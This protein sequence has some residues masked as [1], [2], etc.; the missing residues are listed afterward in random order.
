MGKIYRYKILAFLVIIAFVTATILG[1]VP[2]EASAIYQT[3]TDEI[4]FDENNN[5]YKTGQVIV[6]YR[7]SPTAAEKR[8]IRAT[9]QLELIS[10]MKSINSEVIK[11]TNEKAQ[12]ALSRLS[13]NPNVLFAEYNYLANYDYV[14]NDVRYPYQIYLHYMNASGAWDYTKGSAN[15]TIAVID[16]GILKGNTDL[17][18]ISA[19]GYNV[20]DSSTDYSDP[21]GHGTG[22]I[23][24][25]GAEMDNSFGFA[26]VAPES[27]FMVLRVIDEQGY[28][29]YSDMILALEYAMNQGVD[30]INMSVSGRSDS[31]SLKMAI[32]DAYNSGISIIASAGNE[33]STMV[34]YPAAYDNVIGV[35]AVNTS[36]ELM[37]FSNTGNGLT[38]V[39]GGSAMI[40]T[41][42]DYITNASGTSFASPYVA[43]LVG[44]MYAVDDNMTPAKAFNILEATST[45]LGSSGYDTNFGYGLINMGAAVEMAA[46]G[47]SAPTPEPVTDTTPPV[48]TLNGDNQVSIELGS[49]Y[50]DPG[51][52]AIDDIDGDIS[53]DVVVSGTIDLS[54]VGSYTLNYVVTDQAGNESNIESRIV[55]VYDGSQVTQDITPPVL[56]LNGSD[57][58]DVEIGTSYTELGASAIDDYDG[59]LSDNVVIT[60][61]VDVSTL[62][63]YTLEYS[64]T[65]QAGNQS[66]VE[67]RVVEVF[68]YVEEPIETEI[69]RDVEIVSG[70]LNK[71][72]T[73]DTHT[74][75][76]T[77]AGQLD[78]DFAYTGKV[79]P[80]LTVDGQTI[81]GM[82]GTLNVLEGSYNM[83]ISANSNAKYT[84]TLTHP[85]REVPLGTPLGPPEIIIYDDEIEYTL[86][87]IIFAIFMATMTVLFVSREKIFKLLRV[88]K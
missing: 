87:I 21:T 77:E 63:F 15:V 80:I 57:R 6:G 39:A 11:V 7:G 50:E 19:S 54:S 65:D 27:S 85:E 66:N 24:V 9:M 36:G 30:V 46:S 33:S 16:T 3:D 62:G 4:S 70:S 86:Q 45:D 53:N 44:L 42:T 47:I 52:N 75:S 34:S 40:A 59:D 51:A 35:G 73:E 48:L 83:S 60:G 78:V 20:A 31:T 64:A 14:P 12:E 49:I 10:E 38:V 67:S 37:T 56:T 76:I 5:P 71:R 81:S 61:T 29:T 68:E 84:V 18:T 88:N 82:S 17:K 79:T 55:D 28:T 69:V 22:V 32:D 23:S 1:I 26:G 74:I 13:K 2:I 43:G 8:S 25:I 41:S 72:N 58:I